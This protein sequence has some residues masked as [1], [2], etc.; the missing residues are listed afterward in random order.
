MKNSNI[1]L[2]KILDRSA[3]GLVDEGIQIHSEAKPVVDGGVCAAGTFE[4]E[5][6]RLSANSSLEKSPY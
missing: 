5:G 6:S 2:G 4:R 1:A 3:A